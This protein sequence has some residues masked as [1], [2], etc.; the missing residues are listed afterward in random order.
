MVRVEAAATS[1]GDEEGSQLRV[2]VNGR[3]AIVELSRP[4]ACN[5]L[6]ATTL[7]QLALTLSNLCRSRN[8]G[9]IVLTGSGS[10]FCAGADLKE[11][12]R[13]GPALSRQSEA[14]GSHTTAPVPSTWSSMAVE[15]SEFLRAK[16]PPKPQHTSA[17]GSSTRSISR[18]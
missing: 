18:T 17:S 14:G 6:D 11:L 3:T 12:R 16:V 1:G 10:G 15:T 13:D 8:Y 4:H 7:R 2:K 5:A 9:S